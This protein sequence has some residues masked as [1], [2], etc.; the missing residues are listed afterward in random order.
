[1]AGVHRPT[2]LTM[3]QRRSAV[4]PVRAPE[5]PAASTQVVPSDGPAPAA[6]AAT[7]SPVRPAQMSSERL[8]QEA[9]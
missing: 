7:V 5:N 8:E 6:C 4:A 3:Q 9:W 1:M 2:E